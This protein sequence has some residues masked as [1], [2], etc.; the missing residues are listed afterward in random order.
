[1][2]EHIQSAL[3]LPASQLEQIKAALKAAEDR[4]AWLMGHCPS[5]TLAIKQ[6]TNIMAQY[7]RQI[8]E[9]EDSWLT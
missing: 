3:P 8:S 5:N 7:E 9:L 2:K 4:Y 1:M 6:Q